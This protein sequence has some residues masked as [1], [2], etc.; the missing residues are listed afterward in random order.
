VHDASR[1][2]WVLSIPLPLAEAGGR[3]ELDLTVE[4]PHN[5]YAAQDEWAHL[6]A[7]TRLESPEQLDPRHAGDEAI[8]R[9]AL[10]VAHLL[11]RT[12]E[13]IAKDCL[14]AN[15]LWTTVPPSERVI[16]GLVAAID[17][18][19]SQTDRAR[20]RFESSSSDPP[21]LAR[22]KDIAEEFVSSRLVDWLS[23][24]LQTVETA[25]AAPD[26]RF[27]V[28]FAALIEP[29]RQRLI[30]A[31]EAELVRRSEHG[32]VNPVAEAPDTLPRYIERSSQL[33]KHFQEALFL[34][35]RV[36]NTEHRVRNLIAIFAAAAASMVYFAL[37]NSGGLKAI[38]G[39][40]GA[41][42]LLG[43]IIYAA[44]DRIK[45]LSKSW[46]SSQFTRRFGNRKISVRVPSRIAQGD[47]VLEEAREA[48]ESSFARRCDELNPDIG[49]IRRVAVL[50]LRRSASLRAQDATSARLRELGFMGWKHIFRYDLSAVLPRLDD[51]IK[52]IPAYDS[53]RRAISVM[54]VPKHYR[55]PVTLDLRAGAMHETVEAV[56]VVA[57]SGIV[58]IERSTQRERVVHPEAERALWAAPS[59]AARMG[60]VP[61]ASDIATLKCCICNST[62]RPSRSLSGAYRCTGCKAV[63]YRNPEGHRWGKLRLA[64]ARWLHK[65]RAGSA[66]APS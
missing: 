14:L 8:R 52:R 7:L 45:E 24:V 19:L 10:A 3:Y 1:L 9:A 6:Q 13:R 47:P 5:I 55:F 65:R 29:A 61:A 40:M 28:E 15:S 25:L 12:H 31:L 20:A 2:E 58:G 37:S 18:A 11:K 38:S 39:S 64:I 17:D 59:P 41:T 23:L 33:K 60:V 53:S 4:L 27:G 16:Q 49:D 48:F 51:S 66:S 36:L 21:A 44:K 54:A 43:A 22:E 46:L 35:Q 56:L 32:W 63:T 62:V 50:R 30:G 34:E 42:A 26:S 57:K